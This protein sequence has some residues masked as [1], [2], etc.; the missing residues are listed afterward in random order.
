MD[1]LSCDCEGKLRDF[2]NFT[3]LQRHTNTLSLK[4]KLD[5]VFAA[6]LFPRF[7]TDC[8]LN[9]ASILESLETNLKEDDSMFVKAVQRIFEHRLL[10]E[11]ISMPEFASLKTNLA[12]I[13]VEQA[14]AFLEE[15]RC[16]PCAEATVVEWSP[17]LTHAT[18]S[19]TAP[20]HLGAGKTALAAMF[21]LVKY[22]KKEAGSPNSALAILI[23]ARDHINEYG[24]QGPDANTSQHFR[25]ASFEP[26]RQQKR[27]YYTS[28]A[29][30]PAHAE[31]TPEEQ[32]VR[33][34]C[35]QATVNRLEFVELKKA[36]SISENDVLTGTDGNRVW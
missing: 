13:T 14:R 33:G 35:G 7:D 21:Y 25:Y 6:P 4:R 28:L 30:T 22:L 15:V 1:G 18:C 2:K 32:A 17:E 9:T 12:E 34:D 29:S 10:A 3:G 24:S 23:D 27:P 36:D 5:P 26:L 8:E 19:N 16:L 20:Y 31:R 11:V